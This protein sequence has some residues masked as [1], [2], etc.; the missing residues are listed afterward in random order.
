LKLPVNFDFE[1][2]GQFRSKQ[3]TIQGTQSSILWADLGLRKKMVKEKRWSTLDRQGGKYYFAE[4]R[5]YGMMKYFALLFLPFISVSYG[6]NNPSYIAYHQSCRQAEQLFL[7]GSLE[8]CFEVYEQTFSTYAVLFPRDCFMAAQFAHKV[9]KDS[10]A[11]EFLIDAIPFG[12]QSRMLLLDTTQHPYFAIQ[13]VVQSIYF[14]KLV[15][16][17][18]SLNTIYKNNVDWQLKAEIME[19]VRLDQDWRRRNN[20]WFNRNFRRGLEKLFEKVNDGHMSYLD[21]VFNT[22]GYP[23]S[24]LIGVGDSQYYETSYPSFNNVNLSEMTKILL[25]HNDSVFVKYGTFLFNEIDKGHIHPR[26][27]AMVRDFRDRHLVN[28]D[29]NESMYY[30]V[31]W[32]RD[33]Y[34]IE[35][36]NQHCQEIGC[37][38]K[39]H[40][41]ML[42]KN[43][44]QGYDVFWFPFR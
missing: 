4:W 39:Q 22:T 42:N 16:L 14:S 29:K 25:Y 43:L 5:R 18:D 19:M 28:K 38:T 20:K 40:L 36:F 15:N 3:Q 30:N 21:S 2:T 11:V 35:E 37:P 26:A 31:W 23:G 24:W 12:L 41:R 13:S 33:N 17:E 10:L 9:G 32:Q 1:T 27:Y 34:S 44:G 7:D 6:Q 8:E